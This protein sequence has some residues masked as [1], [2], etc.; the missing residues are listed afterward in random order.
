MIATAIYVAGSTNLEPGRRYAIA[1][2]G[3]R[4]QILGPTDIDPSRMAI[5]RPLETLDARAIEGRFIVSDQRGWVLAFM[6]V[7]GAKPADLAATVVAAASEAV[8]P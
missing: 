4:L 3:T 7:A 8:G 6:S 1:I 2:E 5:D